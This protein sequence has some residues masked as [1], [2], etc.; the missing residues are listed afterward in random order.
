MSAEASSPSP[1]LFNWQPPRPRRLSIVAFLCGSIAFHAI[2][3]YLFQI[4]YAPAVVLL[5]PPAR[6]NVING[7]TE[8][9]KSLL[10]WIDAEDPA[11]ASATQRPPDSRLR[12]LPRVPHV[13]SYEDEGPKLKHAPPFVAES[14]A[15]ALHPPGPVAA[16]HHASPVPLGPVPTRM[17]FSESL[18]NLGAAR[19]PETHFIATSREAPQAVQFRIAVGTDGTVR[20]CFAI[21]SSGDAALDE[22]ARQYLVMT[23]FAPTAPADEN[24]PAESVSETWGLA[25]LEWGNDVALPVGPKDS[26]SP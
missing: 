2:C 11:L 10:R 26:S 9:G 21:N 19:F 14:R 23:R 12:Q 22:Q 6:V 15:P 24:A 8:E 1:L 20:H 7:D 25:T 17:Y 18:T 13:P 5:P 3:F 16:A 4:V